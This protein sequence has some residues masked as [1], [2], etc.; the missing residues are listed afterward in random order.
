VSENENGFLLKRISELERELSA[1]MSDAKKR[2]VQYR[3]A[4]KELEALRVEKATWD[5][6]RD[7]LKSSPTEW[8]EK[9]E[10]IEGELRARD[11]RDVWQKAI[12]D[13]LNEKVTLEKVWAEIQYKPGDNLPSESEIKTQVKAARDAAPYL[14]RQS[15]EAGTPAPVGAQLPSKGPSHVPFDGSRG[16]RDTG[17]ARF[18]VLRSDMRDSH[19]MMTHSKAIAEASRKGILDIVPD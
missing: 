7:S 13:Q 11:H 2:R 9:Y 10:K 5:K 8:Q 16:D 18:K 12:G 4:S 3:D 15:S 14:F 19:F 1:A 6:E 17:S